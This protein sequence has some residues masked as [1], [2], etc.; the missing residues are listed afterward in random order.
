MSEKVTI[1]GGGVVGLCSAYFLAKAH[2]EVTIV[3]ASDMTDGCSYGNAGMIVPSHIVPLAQ[4]GMIAQGVRWMFDSKSPFYIQPRLSTDLIRWGY[5]FYKYANE[6]HVNEAMPALRDLSLLSKALFK[7]FAREDD[8]FCY[9]EKGLLMLY[10]TDKM[11]EGVYHEAKA[12][13]RMGLEADYLNEDDVA[14][15][16]KG[17][18]TK[19]LGGVHFKGDAHLY[20]QKF[21]AFLKEKLT[22]LGVTMKPLTKVTNFRLSNQNTVTEVITN[23]GGIKTDHVVLASGAWSAALAKKLN[24]PLQL[25]PGKGYSITTAQQEHS[26]SIPTVLC[27][28]KVA[29]TPMGT[30]IRF[31]GTLEITHVKDHQ[32]K[33]NR[34]KG[35]VDSVNDFYPE[36]KLDYP[37]IEDVWYG[38]RP[39]TPSGLPVIAKSKIPN[40][41]VATGHAMMGLSLGPATGK[42]VSELIACQKPSVAINK[43]QL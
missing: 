13:Q 9:E 17:S 24:I 5:S 39:C 19:V 10:K 1:I 11:A 42:I 27:E 41:V 2:Y 14:Q 7:E 33:M 34:L 35:I 25:L 12:A 4:P 28:G 22:A 26:P 6:K 36:L 16:E 8:S 20:P 3:D 30:D 29:V 18:R 38:Y 15:L 37:S 31:G 40:V 21:L 32:I 23:N 43:F